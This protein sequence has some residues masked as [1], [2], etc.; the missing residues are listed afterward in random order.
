MNPSAWWSLPPIP[1]WETAH[2]IVVHLPIGVLSVVPLIALWAMVAGK[3][4]RTVGWA[5]MLLVLMGTA[6]TVVAAASGGEA[7]AVADAGA[8]SKILDRHEE[9]GDLARNCFLLVAGVYAAI[10]I[11][12]TIMK[13]KLKRPI[14]IVLHA[15]WLLGFT[16]AFLVLAN[17]GHLGGRLVHEYGVRAPIGQK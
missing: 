1:T 4:R 3:N 9:L 11:L 8:G 14:W 17:A 7:M 5:V 6:G 15:A 12:S 2:P 10:T 13:D 16:A